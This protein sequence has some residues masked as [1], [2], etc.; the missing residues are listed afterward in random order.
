VFKNKGYRFD[1]KNC[2]WLVMKEFIYIPFS[3]MTF[4]IK[5]KIETNC[6]I[7]IG[8]AFDPEPYNYI[9]NNSTCFLDD[10]FVENDHSQL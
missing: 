6:E 3:Y 4:V 7:Q 1:G 8:N 5:D 9:F 2:N 10:E